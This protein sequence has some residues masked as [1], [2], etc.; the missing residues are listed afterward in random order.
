MGRGRGWGRAGRR[1]G[2][3]RVGKAW[4]TRAVDRQ[5][6]VSAPELKRVDVKILPI[7]V[8]ALFREE[9]VNMLSQPFSHRRIT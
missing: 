1:N 3:S 8:N 2:G 6:V 4:R 7:E 9:I 5:S